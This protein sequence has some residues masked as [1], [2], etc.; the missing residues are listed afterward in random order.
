MKILVF[1]DPTTGE[2]L[3]R[4]VLAPSGHTAVQT[5]DLQTARS[6]IEAESVEMAIVDCRLAAEGEGGESLQWLCGGFPAMPKILLSPPDTQLGETISR[7]NGYVEVL[8]LPL[9]TDQALDAVARGVRYR[10]ALM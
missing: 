10:Q 8:S 9:R 7:N 3:E 4:G 2:L 6:L 1:S 5:Q